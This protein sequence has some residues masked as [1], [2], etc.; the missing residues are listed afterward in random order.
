M[1]KG[2]QFSW[3]SMGNIL[4]E[5]KEEL[6]SLI[7]E[8]EEHN[9]N[10]SVKLDIEVQKTTKFQEKNLETMNLIIDKFAKFTS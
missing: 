8:L 10:F 6:L 4:A 7:Y 1:R 5:E 3:K 2:V 9:S